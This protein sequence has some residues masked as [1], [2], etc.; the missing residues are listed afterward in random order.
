VAGRL[1][2]CPNCLDPVRVPEGPSQLFD[3]LTSGAVFRAELTI[4]KRDRA[5][6]LHRCEIRPSAF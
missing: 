6:I 2:V 3:T 1:V 5:E 4:R